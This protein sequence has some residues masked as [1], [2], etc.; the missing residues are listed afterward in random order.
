MPKRTK[1]ICFH[2]KTN[3][4]IFLAVLLIIAKNWKQLKCL[5]TDE[6]IEKYVS[7]QWNLIQL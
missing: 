5:S 2:T 6:R 1:K 7:I 3:T 4:Q